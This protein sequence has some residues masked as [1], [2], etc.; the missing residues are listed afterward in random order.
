M[1]SKWSQVHCTYQKD[2]TADES[3]VAFAQK[4]LY[5]YKQSKVQHYLKMF[6]PQVKKS[7]KKR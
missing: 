7:G 4:M 6:S 2:L 3:Y 5:T 1:N